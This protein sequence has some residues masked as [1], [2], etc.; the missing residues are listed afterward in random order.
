MAAIENV[1]LA[2]AVPVAIGCDWEA[3]WPS[4]PTRTGLCGSQSL[5]IRSGQIV[6]PAL[7]THVAEKSA[8]GSPR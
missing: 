4:V 1:P 8:S 2:D 3:V 7:L 6:S 5:A